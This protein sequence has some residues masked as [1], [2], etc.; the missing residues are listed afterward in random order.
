MTDFQ[1]GTR[2]V[3]FDL[4][5]VI[6]DSEPLH[7]VSF[8]R[9]FSELGME[10][11]DIDNWQRFIGTSDGAAL[12]QLLNG[13]DTGTP[14]ETLLQRKGEHFLDLLR[15]REPIFPDIPALVADLSRQYAL[16]V[17]SGSL[18]TAIAGTL[19]LRGLRGF[20]RHTVSVQDVE[21]G[22]PAPDLF[23]RA[24][25]LLEIPPPACVVIEDSEAGVAAARAAGMRV[26]AITNTMSPERLKAADALVR[27]YGAVRTL[28][29]GG[30]D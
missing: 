22:K 15:E 7:Q 18:R 2:A 8:L 9:L 29:L 5:G 3:I 17:A 10:P 27:D 6:A 24:A 26:I 1:H 14:F 19:A 21:R 30:R 11:H 12:A 28:L 4:D 25:T 20:F 13:R 23:L 16:A